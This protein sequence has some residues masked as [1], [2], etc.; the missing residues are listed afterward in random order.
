MNLI[1]IDPTG[2]LGVDPWEFDILGWLKM[3]VKQPFLDSCSGLRRTALST[4][5]GCTL[6]VHLKY[7]MVG[8]SLLSRPL[9]QNL[10]SRLSFDDHYAHHSLIVIEKNL[11]FKLSQICNYFFF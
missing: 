5:A 3:N 6:H 8:C 7:H 4:W 2:G 10:L 11:C 9:S 1:N